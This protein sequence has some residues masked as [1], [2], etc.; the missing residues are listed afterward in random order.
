MLLNI[1]TDEE[2]LTSQIVKTILLAIIA[3]GIAYN[4]FRVMR[5]ETIGKK[6]ANITLLSLLVVVFSFVFRQYRLE[7]ALLKSPEY[8]TGTT[9]GYCSV[10]AQGLGIEFEYEAK[11]KKFVNC[12]TFHPIPKKNI[13]VPGGKYLV[14]FSNKYPGKGRM[15]F[16]KRA[17]Y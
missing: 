8:I 16:G 5:N 7:A 4:L 10:F 17:E 14:R 15:D 12:N 13:Q 3:T 11:G 1:V 6:L 9:T 2:L